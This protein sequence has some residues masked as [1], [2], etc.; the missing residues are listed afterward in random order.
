[1]HSRAPGKLQLNKEVEKFTRE[2]MVEA[3]VTTELSLKYQ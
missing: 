3:S 2:G 1:M